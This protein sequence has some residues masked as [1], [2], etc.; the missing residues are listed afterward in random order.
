MTRQITAAWETSLTREC[1][2]ISLKNLRTQN[3]RSLCNRPFL[4][5]LDRCFVPLGMEDGRIVKSRLRA[6][7]MYNRYYGPYNAR[8]Q[9]RNYGAIRGGWIARARNT[10]QWIQVDLE[11]VSIVKGVATQGR[12]DANQYVKSYVI[13]F[14]KNGRRFIPYREGRKI[15]VGS[16]FIS[17]WHKIYASSILFHYVQPN[18]I[19][20]YDML[21]EYNCIG[22]SR[23]AVQTLFEFMRFKTLFTL[24]FINTVQ[25]KTSKYNSQWDYT[26]DAINGTLPGTCSPNQVRVG[27]TTFLEGKEELNKGI[28]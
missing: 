14:S 11:R 10:H 2:K 4:V 5:F 18:K 21:N 15:R 23:P 22:R 24:H 17:F 20:V 1:Q 8:L 3:V 16:V 9:A 13:T 7:S 6:S 27:Q 25:N 28:D 12:Y 19:H 26:P